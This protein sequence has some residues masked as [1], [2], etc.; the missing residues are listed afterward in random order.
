LTQFIPE[1]IFGYNFTNIEVNIVTIKKK[2]DEKIQ[3]FFTTFFLIKNMFVAIKK[4]PT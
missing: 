2:S 4:I 1:G 3:V